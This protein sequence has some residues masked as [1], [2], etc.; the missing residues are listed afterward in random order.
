MVDQN[1]CHHYLI[2]PLGI[3]WEEGYIPPTL[4]RKFQIPLWFKKLCTTDN[5]GMIPVLA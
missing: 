2:C 1:S 5:L 4:T 3:N